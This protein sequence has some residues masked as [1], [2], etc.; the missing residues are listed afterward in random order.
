MEMNRKSCLIPILT[1]PDV[2][3][4]L[5]ILTEVKQISILFF[6]GGHHIKSNASIGMFV[7]YTCNFSKAKKQQQQKHNFGQDLFQ[8]LL[9]CFMNALFIK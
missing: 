1:L 6:S 3:L 2:D 7:L 5:K 8:F 9:S 4:R